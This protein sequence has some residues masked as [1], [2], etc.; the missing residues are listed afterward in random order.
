LKNADIA[1]II[2]SNEVQSVVRQARENTAQHE[3]KKNPLTNEAALEE[4]NPYGNV[5]RRMER[6]SQEH[7]RKKRQE[8]LAAKRGISKS[9]TKEQKTDLKSRKKNSKTWIKN[10]LKNLD[11]AYE[12]EEEK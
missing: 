4:L 9:L 5:L 2:N 10:V 11:D 6:E 3:H 8:A 7:N 1:K 12:G